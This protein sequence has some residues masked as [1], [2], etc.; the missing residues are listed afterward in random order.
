MSEKIVQNKNFE[1]TKNSI[2]EFWRLKS[3]LKFGHKFEFFITF[4]RIV[5]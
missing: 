4:W 3:G 1:I 5:Y 2:I